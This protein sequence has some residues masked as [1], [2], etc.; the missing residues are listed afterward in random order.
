[1]PSINEDL[2]V[3]LTIDKYTLDNVNR[4]MKLRIGKEIVPDNTGQYS[5]PKELFTDKKRVIDE[6]RYKINGS[7]TD[8]I[9]SKIEYNNITIYDKYEK[10]VIL[11]ESPHRNEYDYSFNPIGPAQGV[12]GNNIERFLG[13]LIDRL[14]INQTKDYV[15]ILM[16]PVQWQCS[17]G[18]FYNEGLIETFRNNIWTKL[19]HLY[20]E[21]FKN[22][23]ELYNPS[24]IINTC[25]IGREKRV[26]DSINQVKALS[27]STKFHCHHPSCWHYKGLNLNKY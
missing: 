6:V 14:H 4:K 16:N 1:M 9:G 3:K 13:E 5:I 21:E 19:F 27:N 15:F 18:S 23:I 25:T 26:I 8:F 2:K 24:I 11:L 7:K 12:T 22:Q 17:L 20:S 10:I